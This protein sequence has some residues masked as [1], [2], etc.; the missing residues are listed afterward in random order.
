[1]KEGRRRLIVNERSSLDRMGHGWMAWMGG[2]CSV[3]CLFCV[4]LLF[5][6][7][8][9]LEYTWGRAGLSSK[10]WAGKKNTISLSEL[11]VPTVGSRKKTSISLPGFSWWRRVAVL[12]FDCQQSKGQ[13][14]WHLQPQVY[15][16]NLQLETAGTL[17]KLMQISLES[18]IHLGCAYLPAW[19]WLT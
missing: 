1:M 15:K 9:F 10:F 3:I 4:V 16:Y 7:K 13:G 17:Y 6:G 5:W 12:C 19:Q 8:D 2:W 18:L 11:C 14:G